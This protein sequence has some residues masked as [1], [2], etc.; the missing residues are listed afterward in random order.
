M[1]RTEFLYLNY[2]SCP[3]EEE[4]FQG[5]ISALVES[6]V[7]H[8]VV[9]RTMDLGGDKL[10]HVLDGAARGQPLL[11]V[12]RASASASMPQTCSRRSYAPCSG[13]E[14][15]AKRRSYCR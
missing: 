12:A 15:T 3:S 2:R 6:L 14:Y 11:G 5:L 13:L 9:I 8:P 1:Y 4:Q 7:P 10:S